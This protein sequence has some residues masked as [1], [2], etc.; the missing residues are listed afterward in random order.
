MGSF[1]ELIFTLAFLDLP[2]NSLPHE[3]NRLE[4]MGLEIKAKSNLVI[5]IKDISMSE[6]DLKKNLMMTYL[7]TRKNKAKDSKIKETVYVENE[8]YMME[9]IVTNISPKTLSFELLIQIPQ[10]SIPVDNCDYTNTISVSLGNFQT[11]KID[12]YFYFPK[13]GKYTHHPPSAN[14]DGKVISQP[15]FKEFI[16]EKTLVKQEGVE[17]HTLD[18]V[19]ESGSKDEILQFILKQKVI[20]DDDISKLDWLLSNKD[21]C[22]SLYE[23]LRKRGQYNYRVWSIATSNYFNDLAFK[24]NNIQDFLDNVKGTSIKDFYSSVLIDPNDVH[25]D[26][27]PIINSR[28]HGIGE[29]MKCRIRNKELRETYKR[30]IVKL[31]AQIQKPN[32]FNYLRLTYYLILQDRVEDA[33]LVFDKINLNE[34]NNNHSWQ[35]QYDYIRA[36]LEFSKGEGDFKIAKEICTKYKNFPI[37]FWRNLFEEIEDQLLEYEGAYNFDGIEG[38]LEKLNKNKS[39]NTFKIAA[40]EESKVS[41]SV[42]SSNINLVYYNCSSVKVK[43]Y[44]I[45]IETLFSITPFIKQEGE[46]F[47]YVKASHEFNVALNKA[48]KE[49]T[50][51]IPIPE[52]LIHNNLFIEVN[53]DGKRSYDTYF[54]TSLVVTISELFGELKVCN[55]EL[56]TLSKV[57]VKCYAELTDGTTKFYKDGYTD[58]RGKFNYIA[59]NTD[60]LKRVKKFSLLIMDDKFGSIIKEANP[61]SDIDS[62]NSAFG[63]EIVIGGFN[64]NDM[65]RNDCDKVRN[66]QQMAKKAWKTYNNY[67]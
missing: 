22:I 54:S 65:M 29:E 44:L 8:I 31:F 32:S 10:G 56:K 19:L 48:M 53:N 57:Y 30:F 14:I 61:P 27:H 62:S 28:A 6:F 11:R 66:M 33:L 20:K 42:E 52:N 3:Y 58:L 37:N 55:K 21:F 40:L 46:K 43:F 23:E 12:T 25:Y 16:V 26:Y 38:M 63:G 2:R 39:S 1:S 51:E 45:D 17:Y 47:S 34:F 35:I 24:E 9:T 41:F 36:Y 18:D 64:S 4:N 67:Y 49:Q 15:Q 50:K 60:L 59:I 7:V 13:V 5:F